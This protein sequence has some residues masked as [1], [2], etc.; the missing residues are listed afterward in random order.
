MCV[1]YVY[2]CVCMYVCMMQTLKSLSQ[3]QQSEL[4]WYTVYKRNGNGYSLHNHLSILCQG[5]THTSHLI[6][7][8]V[9]CL[10]SQC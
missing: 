5:K 4:C 3:Q 1:R 8:A 10:Q 7:A 6:V 2:K 9:V